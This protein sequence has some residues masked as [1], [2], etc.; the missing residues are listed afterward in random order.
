MIKETKKKSKYNYEKSVA[1]ILFGCLKTV[2][3]SIIIALIITI[4]LSINARNEMIKN[5]SSYAKNKSMADKEIAK[6]IIDSN[7]DLMSDMQHKSYSVCLNI[8]KLFETAGEY[9]SAQMAYTFA[10]EKASQAN[11]KV[12]YK[13]FCV[14]VLQ[15]K[16]D[17]AI[18]LL[19]SVEDS[20]DADLFKFKTRSYIV[21]GDKYYSIGKFLTAAK[22]YEKAE[23][24]YNK[25][26]R[27]DKIIVKSITNR[28]INSYINAADVI[29]NAGYNSEAVRLLKKV[30]KKSPTDLNIKYKLA[31]I[32][33]DLNPEE[34]IL[35]LEYLL[36]KI[37]QNI[38]YNIYGRT[39]LKAAS[40]ADLDNRP[41]DAKRYRYKIYSIDLFITKKVLYKNDIDVQVAD[42]LIKKVFFKYPINVILKLV[43]NSDNDLNNLKG[44]FILIK[45]N[46]EIEKITITLADK[47]NIIYANGGESKKIDL[48]FKKKLF[49]KRE[50]QRYAIRIY[51][52]K[53]EKYK[54]QISEFSLPVK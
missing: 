14:L 22:Y 16:F 25:F 33:S 53:D 12:R 30:E 43:N 15:E 40:I 50:M 47:K 17:A 31:V 37:P 32:L 39:L 7:F 36:N 52:Y 46:K 1:E 54:T 24:Y 5:I 42:C 2:F 51:L 45:N 4:G 10:L 48:K 49:T 35:Y 9:Q 38:D 3:V 34:S 21:L 20:E 28:I 26:S 23:F 8:G 11:L 13:L 19:D 41:I 27:K 18:E 6:Q 44:D 29:V